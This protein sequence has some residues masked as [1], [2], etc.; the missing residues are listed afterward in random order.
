MVIYTYLYYGVSVAFAESLDTIARDLLQVRPT[1]MTGVPRVYEK[2]HARIEQ[3][4]AAASPL[5]QRLF[6]WALGVGRAYST[7]RLGGGRVSPLLASQH[8]LADHLVFAKIRER[9][10]GRLRYVVSGS[11]P[12]PRAI[13]EFFHAIGLPVIE[14]YGLT[15]TSPVLTTNPE[16]APRFG[17]VGLPIPGVEL[18]LAPDGEILARGPNI[19]LGYYNLPD[20]TAATFVD[21]WYRTGDVG[22][23]S[24]DGYVTITDRKKDLIVTS[25]GKNVAPQPIETQMKLN[26]LVDE[27]VVIGDR[28]NYLVMLIVPNPEQL[29][30]RIAALGR[31]GG[32]LEE[33]V[34]RPDVQA[35][36]QELIDALNRDLAPFEQI[37]RMTLLP[38]RFGVDSGELTPSLKVRRRVI[39]E[40]WRCAIDAL[41]GGTAD[42]NDVPATRRSSP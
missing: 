6:A 20:E 31:P 13:G 22:E 32:T 29:A 28:R 4:A 24:A 3:G 42:A 40:R 10:G 5:R 30:A 37:K 16:K 7:A 17:T 34:G 21:G 15:E 27:A 26:R 35:L 23:I 11:A 39:E 36:Y 18:K 9:T 25:G 14:G 8:W 1:L 19:M 38:V 33:L 12:L 41:Y 2:L